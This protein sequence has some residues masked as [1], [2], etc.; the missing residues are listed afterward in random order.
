MQTPD[1][2]ILGRAGYDL[3]SEEPH[4]PLSQVR[5]FTRYLGG[6]SANMAVGL[7]RLG[8][9][10]G[11]VSCLGAD[12]LSQFLIDFLDRERVD[13]AHIQR[14]RGYL[15]SL[16]LTEVSPPDRFPQVFYRRD[17]ADIMLAATDDDLAYAAA[18]RMFVTN[19]TSL[20]A[21][22]SRESTYLALERAHAAGAQTVFD[23]DFRAMS[24]PGP[25]E[26]GLAVR[27]ALP[28]TS[29]LIGNQPEL[30]LVAGTSTLDEATAWLRPR[31]NILV[32]K[33]GDEGT[34]VFAG[35]T[36]VFL[37]PYRVEVCTT[38]GAGDGFASGFLHALRGELPIEECLHYGNAAAAI[39]V[40]RLSCSEA[41]PTLDEVRVL[42]ESQRKT[43]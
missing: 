5:R 26:A 38:I 27:L 1:I 25:R 28:Y 11:L 9:R 20:C 14:C 3:C 21:S 34:R 36:D 13:T 10:V 18:A 41:M 12:A 19:G 24:W 4:L 6:S 42:I 7:A 39:V 29:V 17:P 16:A 32:S 22:P 33:L 35:D 8:H 40:S 2:V 31:V 43:G 15:P 37:P 30:M 23:V